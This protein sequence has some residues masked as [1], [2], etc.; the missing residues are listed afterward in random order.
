MR[1]TSPCTRLGPPLLRWPHLTCTRA[2][3]THAHTTRRRCERGAGGLG[4]AQQLLYRLPVLE[5]LN[6]QLVDLGLV[7]D[8]A[9]ALIV[10]GR[11][12]IGQ[13]ALELGNVALALHRRQRRPLVCTVVGDGVGY[14][15]SHARQYTWYLWGADWFVLALGACARSKPWEISVRQRTQQARQHG[16]KRDFGFDGAYLCGG[17]AVP[18]TAVHLL[19]PVQGSLLRALSHPERLLVDDARTGPLS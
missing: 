14:S 6:T 3:H 10:K 9:L 19:A 12:R 1:N 18:R 4:Q 5:L 11:A 13:C 2:T 8:A 7:R 17:R 16:T 15:E